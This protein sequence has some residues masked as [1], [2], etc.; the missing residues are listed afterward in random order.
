MGAEQPYLVDHYNPNNVDGWP[1]TAMKITVETLAL[2]AQN[3]R[4][5]VLTKQPLI[6]RFF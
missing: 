6:I 2:A 3:Y 5:S 1:T 4:K